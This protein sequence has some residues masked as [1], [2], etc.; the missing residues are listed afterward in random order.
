MMLTALVILAAGLAWYFPLAFFFRSDWNANA[1]GKSLLVFSSIIAAAMT[2][3]VLRVLGI[4]VPIWLRAGVYGLIVIGLAVQAVTL[5]RVQNRRSARLA[6]EYD[7]T[8]TIKES[9]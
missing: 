7:E 4:G 8:E 1:A 6:R 3:S 9:S 5:T 2:L